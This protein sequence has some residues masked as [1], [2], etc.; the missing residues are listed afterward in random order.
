MQVGRWVV[1]GGKVN[2]GQGRRCLWP[3]REFD[4]GMLRGRG[5]REGGEWRWRHERG[6]EGKACPNKPEK[7]EKKS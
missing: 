3:M 4:G 7:K 2:A 1:G 5:K 6:D